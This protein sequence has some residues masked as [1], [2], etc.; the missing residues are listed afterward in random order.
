MPHYLVLCTCPD[1]ECARALAERLVRERLAACVNIVSQV[2]SVYEWQGVVQQEAEC[3]LLIKTSS[4]RYAAL[5]ET[6]RRHHPYELPEIIA[7]PLTAGLPAYLHWI[8]QQTEN[9]A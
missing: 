7:V 2:H 9:N 5:E 3:Q 4:G 1:L 6:L 8:D